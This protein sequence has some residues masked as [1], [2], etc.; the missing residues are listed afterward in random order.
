MRAAALELAR[1]IRVNVVSPPWNIETLIALKMDHSLG[2]PAAQ[3]AR[4]YLPSM[5][6]TRHGQTIDPHKLA[7]R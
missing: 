6:G 7:A 5:E 4:A 1:G 2:I 3:V